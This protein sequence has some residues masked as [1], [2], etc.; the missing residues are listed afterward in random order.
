MTNPRADNP[1]LP[2]QEKLE[3]AVEALTK[4]AAGRLA[5]GKCSVCG[6]WCTGCLSCDCERGSW[7]PLDDA[8]I[9]RDTLASLG[10]IAPPTAH[11]SETP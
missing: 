3:R 5:N 8:E 9:A 11:R 7:L 4:I 10:D 6:Q 1:I 2:S